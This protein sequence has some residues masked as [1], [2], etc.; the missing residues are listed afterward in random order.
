MADPQQVALLK[1]GAT[2]WNQWRKDTD[3]QPD[4]DLSGAQLNLLDFQDVYLSQYGMCRYTGE[5]EFEPVRCNLVEVNFAGTNLR[6]ATMDGTDL[7]AARFP[8][9]DLQDVGLSDTF[10]AEANLRGARCDGARLTGADLRRADLSEARLRHVS[11]TG[12]DLRG[13]NLT[14]TDL[15]RATFTRARIDR[16]TIIDG[17]VFSDEHDEMSDGTDRLVLGRLDHLVNWA[18][19]RF[20]SELP[21]FGFSYL[22]LAAALVIGFTIHFANVSVLNPTRAGLA[23]AGERL[24]STADRARQ[25]PG[26]TA[27]ADE[28]AGWAEAIHV[29]TSGLPREISLPSEMSWILVS[30]LLLAI[31]ATTFKLACPAT[32]QRFTE[33]EWVAQLRRPRLIY[34]CESLC[35]GRRKR[36]VPQLA[37]QILTGVTVLFGGVIASLVLLIRITRLFGILERYGTWSLLR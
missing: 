27:V 24:S 29:F 21:I 6:G 19:L 17:V 28:M 34:V 18:R 5:G 37:A 14:E 15:T 9:A 8:N 16:S 23:A 1:T 3:H 12:A 10:M 11:L 26:S 35:C 31:G 22:G 25:V 36:R 4:I 7:R 20:L 33:V 2:A 32:I 30:T 13:A